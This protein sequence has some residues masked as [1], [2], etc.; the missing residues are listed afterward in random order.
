VKIIAVVAA[1]AATASAQ[2][3]QNATAAEAQF[4]KG[5]SLEK[6]GNWRDAC[7]AFE[8]SQKLDPQFGTLYNVGECNQ[9]IGKLASAWA[10]Y[11]ELAQ[12]DTNAARRAHARD[13]ASRLEPR[14]AKLLVSIAPPVDHVTLTM[15]GDDVSNLIGI[16][17]PVD[18][19]T[20]ELVASAPGYDNVHATAVVTDEA[21]TVSIA[22]TMTVTKPAEPAPA[23]IPATVS[24]PPLPPPPIEHAGSRRPYAIAAI[25]LGGALVLGGFVAGGLALEKWHD[26]T[27]ECHDRVCSSPSVTTMATTDKNEANARATVADVLIAAGAVG[28]AIGV[29]LALT[30]PHHAEAATAL[31]VTIGPGSISFGGGF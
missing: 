1:L 8:Q 23:P 5:R 13:L 14:L 25:S 4:E 20:Y 30:E 29:Y 6:A 21:K 7:L 26:A 24:S 9:H 17:S 31:H 28:A 15:N 27:N 22:M 12:R 3:S 19:D 18:P 16:E 11:R 2:P 10:A